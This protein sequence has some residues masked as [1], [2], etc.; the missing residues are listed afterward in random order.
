MSGALGSLEHALAKA[1]GTQGEGQFMIMVFLAPL[2]ECSCDRFPI[3]AR[4]VVDA[5]RFI[6]PTG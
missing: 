1:Q 4:D 2:R 3:G 5:L 6:H